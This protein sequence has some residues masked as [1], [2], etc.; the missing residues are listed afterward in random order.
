MLQHKDTTIKKNQGNITPPKQINKALIMDPE[1][2]KIYQM[3]N[4][5]FRIILRKFMELQKV[6]VEN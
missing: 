2:M 5:E 1:A 4:K 3:T 6:M